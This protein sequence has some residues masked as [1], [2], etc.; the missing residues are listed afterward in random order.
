MLLR[1]FCLCDIYLTV[2]GANLDMH[3]DFDFVGFSYLV[4]SQTA[5]LT[6][7]RGTGDWVSSSLS[8][9]IEIEV[10]GVSYLATE[11]RNPEYPISEDDCLDCV[12]VVAAEDPTD[13]CFTTSAPIPECWHHVFQFTSGFAIRLQA[14]EALC[15]LS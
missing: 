6:W 13:A 15:R 2:G 12:S 4:G 3:N 7:R 8:S 14:D 11:P 1:D 10:L 9:L 5:K